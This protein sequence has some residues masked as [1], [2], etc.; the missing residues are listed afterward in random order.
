MAGD[1][2]G[3]DGYLGFLWNHVLCGAEL[4]ALEARPKG[5]TLVLR[6]SDAL[7]KALDSETVRL[8]LQ[9]EVPLAVAGLVDND[10]TPLEEVLRAHALFLPAASPALDLLLTWHRQGGPSLRLV[11][12]VRFSALTTAA[13]KR[14]SQMKAFSLGKASAFA[15]QGLVDTPELALRRSEALAQLAPVLRAAGFSGSEGFWFRAGPTVFQAIELVNSR[16]NTYLG[17]SFRFVF[18]LAEAD[19]RD[20]KLRSAIAIYAQ[21]AK[22]VVQRTNF[23]LLADRFDYRVEQETDATTLGAELKGDFTHCYLPWLEAR[24][25]LSGLDDLSEG[26][27]PAPS[28]P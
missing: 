11:P 17:L 24:S 22:R 25:E 3:D 1:E 5:Q 26:S 23:E 4:V 20:R 9:T 10:V 16:W 18:H 28:V 8:A 12:E 19:L 15:L 21:G 27:G 13:G 7:Q 14:V 6:C 2:Q